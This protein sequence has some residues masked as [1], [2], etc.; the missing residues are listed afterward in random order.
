[1]NKLNLCESEYRFAS[2]VWEDE[3]LGSGEL[4]KLCNEKLGWKKSTTYTVL[5]R[6]CQREI[7]KNEN[8][9]VSAIVKRE[10]VQKFESEQFL[11]KTFNGSLPQFI[12]SF[13]SGKKLS[14]A[15]ADALKKLIDSYKG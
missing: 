3:P 2:I 7:L 10:Q 9:T 6:L 1:M 13:M 12:T 14:K 5:K 8:S 4:V 11:D 15:E